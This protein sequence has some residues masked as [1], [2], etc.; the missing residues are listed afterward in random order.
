MPTRTHTARRYS[1]RPI[2]SDTP[3]AA[4]LRRR[5]WNSKDLAARIGAPYR[6]I[7]RWVMGQTPTPVWVWQSLK[8]LDLLERRR[9]Q[10][11]APA[12]GR[13]VTA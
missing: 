4:E 8:T 7:Q 13:V 6:T 10:S 12:R 11:R 2:T 1:G 5:G 9:K 3:L